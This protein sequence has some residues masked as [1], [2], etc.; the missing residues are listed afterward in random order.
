MVTANG[1]AVTPMNVSRVYR[2]LKL[3]ALL[4]SGRRYDAESLSEAVGVSRRT[5]FRDLRLLEL[6]GVPYRFDHSKHTY[7]ISDSFFLPPLH[8]DLEESLALLMMTRTFVSDQVHPAHSQAVSA[9]LK[10]ESSLPA[11]VLAHCGSWLDGVSMRW[12]PVSPAGTVGA[13]FEQFQRAVAN[14]ERLIVTYDSVYD[15]K[16]ISTLIEPLHL[17]FMSRGWYLLARS[18]KHNAVRT[19]KVD[20]FVK[21]VSTNERFRSDPAWSVEKHFGAAWRMIPEGTTYS[22]RLRFH[23]NVAAS[24]EEVQWHASQ[25]TSRL[26]NGAMLFDAE[27]DGLKEIAS[28]IMGYGEWVEVLAPVELRDMI[29]EKAERMVFHARRLDGAEARTCER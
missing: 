26:E 6:A 28:W 3:I 18:L 9:A 5:M 12:P 24:V 2:L 25:S 4:R 13:I 17:V 10:I 7:S 15:D 23:R 27:V 21:V 22:V 19:F 29:R 14:H 16:E 11:E 20:R 1:R 8:L